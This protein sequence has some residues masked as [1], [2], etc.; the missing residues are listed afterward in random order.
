[1]TGELIYDYN[2]AALGTIAIIYD[3]S[4]HTVCFVNLTLR[5]YLNCNLLPTHYTVCGTAQVSLND[6]T[7]MHAESFHEMIYC[8]EYTGERDGVSVYSLEF[9]PRT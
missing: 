1:M 2:Y 6:M 4:D 5:H 7:L 8:N 3:E 9:F